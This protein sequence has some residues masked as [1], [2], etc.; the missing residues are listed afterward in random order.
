MKAF[1]AAE[2][3]ASHADV[4]RGSSRVPAPLKIKIAI[5]R[6]FLLQERQ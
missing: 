4:I 1:R 2:K 6:R 5:I 3:V